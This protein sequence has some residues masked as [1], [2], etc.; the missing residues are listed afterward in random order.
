[1]KMAKIDDVANTR[2]IEFTKILV[3]I[4]MAISFAGCSNEELMHKP[5]LESMYHLNSFHRAMTYSST[6]PLFAQH[7]PERKR[8]SA[9]SGVNLYNK[10]VYVTA[11][12]PPNTTLKAQEE[13]YNSSSLNDLYN[14]YESTAATF[15]SFVDSLPEQSC[16][17]VPEEVIY[18]ALRPTIEVCYDFLVER[19]FS[20]DTIDN[21][22]L[23]CKAAPSDLIPLILYMEHNEIE[24]LN[25]EEAKV[26]DDIFSLFATPAYAQEVMPNSN[27]LL[28][29]NNI[30]GYSLSIQQ[31]KFLKDLGLCTL[32]G[33]IDTSI[34]MG[35]A[36]GTK[37]WKT[38]VIKKAL[39]TIVGKTFGPVGAAIILIETTRCM[40]NKGHL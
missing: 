10:M 35:V 6:V 39:K 27:N 3:L 29:N 30:N 20:K 16:L 7:K 9:I 22:L 24:N 18:S 40:H 32:N 34:L 5:D 26:E 17:E 13:F 37:V 4:I 15:K 23:E 21:V 1:M 14:L 25:L 33:V 36:G 11:T 38:W 19:G 2:T 31:K 8:I 28:L 12:F